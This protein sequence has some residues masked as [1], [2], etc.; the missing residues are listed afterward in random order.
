MLKKKP[1]HSYTLFL[2]DIREEVSGKLSLIGL[3]GLDLVL[4]VKPPV[5]IPKFCILNRIVG[6][7]GQAIFRFSFKDPDGK[8][9]LSKPQLLKLDLKPD[10]IGN[11]NLVLS[12]FPVSRAGKY[13]FT[14]FLGDE[15]FYTDFFEIKE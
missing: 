14:L 6:G 2:D 13:K 10:T 3:Y 9:L 7:E 12:P 8:E 1:K 11:L 5:M 15:E 4:G